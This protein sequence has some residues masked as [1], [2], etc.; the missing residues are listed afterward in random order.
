[1][2]LTSPTSGCRSV[3]IVR[4]RTKAP[5]FKFLKCHRSLYMCPSLGPQVK[6]MLQLTVSRPVSPGVKHPSGVQGQ[7]FVTVRLLRVCCCEAPS[8]TKGRV[9]RLQFLEV[10]A[11]AH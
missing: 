8:L 6:D 2:A 11:S 9:C 7:I 5:E 1:L 4:W 3:G 10:L